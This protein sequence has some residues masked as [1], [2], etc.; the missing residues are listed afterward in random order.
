MSAS[1]LN[2][3]AQ[4]GAQPGASQGIAAQA[5]QVGQAKGPLAGFEAL[6][7]AL[8]GDQSVGV[9]I[10]DPNAAAGLTGTKSAGKGLAAGKVGTGGAKGQ[11][12]A[13]DGTDAAAA[14]ATAVGASTAP[15]ATLALLIPAPTAATTT[16]AA[17]VAANGNGAGAQAGAGQTAATVVSDKAA[18]SQAKLAGVVAAT[19]PT[20]AKTAVAVTSAATAT[21]RTA[22]QAVDTAQ[23]AQA[24]KTSVAAAANNATP[25]A[26]AAQT[27]QTGQT[28][29]T[30]QASQTPQVAAEPLPA[31][32]QAAQTAALAQAAP[33][34]AKADQAKPAEPV[35]AATKDK[36][37]AAKSARVEGAHSDAV[38]K[39]LAAVGKAG[40]TAQALAAS[41]AGKDAG[42]REPAPLTS[43]ASAKSPST[44]AQAP[45]ADFST[46]STTTPA[47]LLHAAAVAVRG[48]PQTVANL[49]AQIAKKLD[50]RSS[51]FD[52]QLDPAGLGKVD[53]R[54]EI[55][56]SGK[57]S[58]AMT[59]DT[60]AAAAELRARAGELQ[61]ALEQAGFDLSGGMSFDVATD[62]GQDGRN[63]DQGAE[64]GAQ[65]R[66]RAFQTAL[67]TSSDPAPTQLTFRRA[68]AA[69]VDIRI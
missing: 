9:G 39:G 16:A 34:L 27:S 21:A 5:A 29:Q 47:T 63:Q 55:G 8:F 60:P 6:L 46:A 57:M 62:R 30:A 24:A 32:A 26:Q 66:G 17:A 13:G 53:V 22:G 2:F 68:S 19:E 44:E 48:A 23:A 14:K 25:A 3:T 1:L 37:S 69:G 33:Q 56:A 43:A 54:L 65:F 18:A 36:T 20:A 59:F 52:V 49:A 61:K 58:A 7:A 12:K 51:R 41:T 40:D 64:S 15:G 67:D 4:P 35:A 38:P 42:A 50:G 11:A 45:I 31:A 10:V 28:S